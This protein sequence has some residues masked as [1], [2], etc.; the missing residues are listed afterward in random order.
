MF[1]LSFFA[2]CLLGHVIVAPPRC[3]V[4]LPLLR[5][6]SCACL[7]VQ[8]RAA[9]MRTRLVRVRLFRRCGRST[10]VGGARRWRSRGCP[11]NAVTLVTLRIGDRPRPRSLVRTSPIARRRIRLCPR[12]FGGSRRRPP[13]V[14]VLAADLTFTLRDGADFG[15]C[16]RPGA[17]EPPPLSGR[18]RL[19]V[20]CPL[21]RAGQ[22]GSFRSG[23]LRL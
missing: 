8:L 3:P 2:S 1:L 4:F 11:S 9:V 17:G 23:V 10:A 12:C 14:L 22:R 18:C 20:A 21:V 13:N 7:D 16:S 5:R 19:L 15:P 6:A